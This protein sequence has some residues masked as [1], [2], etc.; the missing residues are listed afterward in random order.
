LLKRSSTC[1]GDLFPCRYLYLFLEIP[2]G[3]RQ[4]EAEGLVPVFPAVPAVADAEFGADVLVAH[5]LVEGQGQ[6]Q[7][8]V[9]IAAVEEPLH[10]TE[11]LQRGVIGLVDEGEG[12]VVVDGFGDDVELVLGVVPARL[13]VVQP[14]AHRVAA[15]EH[16]RVALGIDGAAAAAHGQAHHGAVLLVGLDPVAGLERGHELLEEEVLVG[17]SGHVEIAVPIVVDVGV[18]CVG[19]DDHRRHDFTAGDEFIDHI[20]HVARRRPVHIGAVQAMEQVDDRIQ[21]VTRGVVAGGIVHIDID[22]L[23]EELAVHGIGTD[24]AL[25][26]RLAES[27]RE[28]D[29]ARKEAEERSFHIFTVETDKCNEL[30]RSNLSSAIKIRQ[31]GRIVGM[32]RY[33]RA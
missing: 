11:F 17:T 10:G 28:D 22:S 33:L 29:K 30:I 8:V 1:V 24:L 3:E 13:G 12:R 21:P 14:G 20:L 23:A 5:F 15:G 6:V 31:N 32:D 9:V 27:G 18:A 25:A 7:E 26:E 4:R 16:V 2:R 19:H